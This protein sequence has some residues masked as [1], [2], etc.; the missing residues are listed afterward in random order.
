MEVIQTVILNNRPKFRACYDSVQAKVPEL[1]GDLTL[2]FV[3]SAEGRV[4]KAELN[5]PRSTIK[6]AELTECAIGELR[7]LQF[8]ASSKGLETK[9][10]YPFNFNPH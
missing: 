3:L 10:N 1:K 9:V 2:H 5:Q 8:P 4:K 7:K 6:N